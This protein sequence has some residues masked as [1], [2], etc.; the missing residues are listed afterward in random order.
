MLD[1]LITPPVGPLDGIIAMAALEVAI[2]E[3]CGMVIH[4][5]FGDLLSSLIKTKM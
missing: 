2:L 1:H 3:I 4:I 5:C